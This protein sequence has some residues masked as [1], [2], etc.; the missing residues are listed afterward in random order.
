MRTAMIPSK[1]RVFLTSI[2][3][4]FLSFFVIGVSCEREPELPSMRSEEN[5]PDQV[6][7]RPHIVVSKK[8]LIS[9]IVE[10]RLMKV[11]EQ[12][13]LTSLEDSILVSFYDK[14]GV[15]TTTL[16]A[17]N[18]EIWGLY[19]DVDSLKADGDVII[20]SHKE[21]STLKTQAI[22]LIVSTHRIYADGHVKITTKDG[23]EEGTGF[24]AK[25]DLSEYEFTGPV[26]GEVRGKQ[27][28]FPGR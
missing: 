12:R 5:A 27:V 3:I 11:Y 22:R 28:E 24:I 16:T 17:L 8:A 4:F 9:A 15:H 7:I 13:N 21:N 1:E 20:V 10:A 6:F 14:E 2:I 18:G 25:D 23:Y 19:E 26:S